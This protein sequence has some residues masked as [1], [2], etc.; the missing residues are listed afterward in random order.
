MHAELPKNLFTAFDWTDD[1]GEL[2]LLRDTPDP[3]KYISQSAENS[4]GEV[5][6]LDLEHL[7]EWLRVNSVVHGIRGPLRPMA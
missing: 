7:R 4:E 3:E 1:A 5:F 2:E 6:E